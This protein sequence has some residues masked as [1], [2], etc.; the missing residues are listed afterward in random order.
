MDED[1]NI[2]DSNF[3]NLINFSNLEGIDTFDNGFCLLLQNIRSIKNNIDVLLSHIDKFSFELNIIALTET[4]YSKG[5]CPKV[6]GFDIF[7]SS[8]SLNQ[9]S[10]VC[11]LVDSRITAYPFHI[12][13]AT[14]YR[15]MFDYVFVKWDYIENNKSHST[16]AGV[17][18]RSPST[19]V[20]NFLTF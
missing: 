1:F 17:I 4:W 7:E 8:S 12:N 16:I 15:T 3:N 2:V 18:Y 10:G 20:H 5:N 13:T 9:S 11:L 14:V 6:E 19:N